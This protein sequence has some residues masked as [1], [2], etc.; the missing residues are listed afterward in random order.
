LVSAR[1]SHTAMAFRSPSSRKYATTP[2]TMI[3]PAAAGIATATAT[4]LWC[5]GT[6]RLRPTPTAE[7]AAQATRPASAA[8]LVPCTA[9][10]PQIRRVANTSG[11]ATTV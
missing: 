11:M 4:S 3:A 7:P 8:C 6:A 10:G 5:S 2:N 1:R 9:A